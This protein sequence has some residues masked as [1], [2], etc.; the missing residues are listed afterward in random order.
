METIVEN[1]EQCEY[2]RG[3]PVDL[4]KEEYVDYY[5]TIAKLFGTL[6]IQKPS[7]ILFGIYAAV[8]LVFTVMTYMETHVLDW[9][10]LAVLGVTLISAGLTYYLMPARMRRKAA[11]L[12][13]A[14]N[15]NGYYG[16]LLVSRLEVT[17]LV[18]EGEDVTVPLT[19]QSIFL[20]NARFM[21]LFGVASQKAIILPARC[22]TPAMAKAIRE[23]VFA[24]GS[25]IHRRVIGRMTAGATDPVARRDLLAPAVTEY[26]C[27]VEYTADE[28]KQQIK[29]TG[30]NQFTDS[31]PTVCIFALLIGSMTAMLQESVIWFFA[32]AL[33]TVIAMLLIS[34]VSSS[35]KAKRAAA[36][37]QNARV[38]FEFNERG[39][40]I[41]TRGQ[42]RK[43][44]L[45]WNS[46]EYITEKPDR[47]ELSG[48]GQ[49]L[50]IPK[51]H[52][53]DMNALSAVVDAYHQP[54][55]VKNSK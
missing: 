44:F 16:E 45:Q 36:M 17:K 26:T 13:D 29:D 5:M 12:Y 43:V 14:G 18:G 6:R 49:I 40:V 53:E 52:I 15:V 35:S 20:E 38:R 41:T 25:R 48:M 23:A 28:I 32:A 10:M 2:Q 50:Y 3:T 22:V 51:R 39:V 27:E 47:V 33:A 31:L 46:L 55:S 1:E 9:L 4:T 19:E 30:N 21:A 24:Q 11:A 7:M 42:D 37:P 8:S 54:R 34:I